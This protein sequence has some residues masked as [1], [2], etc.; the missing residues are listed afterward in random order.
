MFGSVCVRVFEQFR[1]TLRIGEHPYAQAVARMELFDKKLTA[2]F[3][4]WIQL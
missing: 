1:T 2:R 4:N 3:N